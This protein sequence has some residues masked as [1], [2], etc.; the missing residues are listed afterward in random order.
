MIDPTTGRPASTGV[1]AATVLATDGWWAEVQATSLLLSG[2]AGI[3][4]ADAT[5]EAVVVLADQTS[6]ATP[7]FRAVLR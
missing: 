1:V 5:V 4:A 3:A 2:A 7:A 6:H